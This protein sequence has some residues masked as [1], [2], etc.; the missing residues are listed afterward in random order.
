[1]A[2]IT[3]PHLRGMLSS[4]STMAVI[5]GVLSQLLLGTFLKWRI[6]AFFNCLVPVVA[7]VLLFFVPETPVWLI[8]KG[9]FLDARKSIA[10]LRGW[11]SLNEIELEFQE[12]CK[13]LGKA[14][15]I[16]IEDPGTARVPKLS[17]SEH[18]RLFV[19]KSF[20][21]PY[22]LVALA[23]FLSHFNGMQTLQTY[24]IK[25]FA[26]LK[27]PIDKYYATV[28]LGIVEL[29]GSVAC[30]TLVHFLGKRVIN[31]ISLIGSGLC[32]L[33]VG[34]YCYLVGVQNLDNTLQKDG[35]YNWVP[36][37]FLISS[38]FLSYVGIR[39]LPWI[40]TG[41]VYATETRATASGLS[42]AIGYIFS[43][44]ANKLFLSMIATFTLAGTFW[45]NTAVNLLGAILLYFLLPETEGKTL[46]DI[47]E[48]FSGNTKLD[49][50][51]RRTG[52]DNKAFEHDESP[53]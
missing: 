43:F 44:L 39:V 16:G 41:E 35:T 48:H 31:F 50:K 45:F 34:T 7:F 51:V 3:Q 23:F 27:S 15:D 38:A 21:W 6:V 40:L 1:M 33:V 11:T 2:E 4:T 30:V 42:A 12:L 10:W 19:A 8:T 22:A 28:I 26:S 13:Q 47:T 24:A 36:T 18:L 37:F 29:L 20:L 46:Y 49:N 9:R 17:K 25:V 32:F 14:S 53:L 52:V 5:V